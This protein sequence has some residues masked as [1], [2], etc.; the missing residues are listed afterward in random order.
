MEILYKKVKYGDKQSED[1]WYKRCCEMKILFVVIRM[2][3]SKAEI[4]WDCMSTELPYS[5]E[6]LDSE[7]L[8][9]FIEGVF[10]TVSSGKEEIEPGNF[11]GTMYTIPNEYAELA[12]KGIFVGLSQA[13]HRA[14]QK[15]NNIVCSWD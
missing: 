11:T 1:L 4:H 2:Q 13:I 3:A 5:D 15:E 9:G 14:K 12:A 8:I 10:E 6:I 7:R